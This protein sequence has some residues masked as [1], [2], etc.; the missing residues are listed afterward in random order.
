MRLTS[1]FFLREWVSSP[2]AREKGIVN[3][4]NA[5][6]LERICWITV[7][8]LERIRLYYKKPV[9]ITSGFR[10][11]ELNQAV[12]GTLNSAHRFPT[13]LFTGAVD[14]QVSGVSLPD[15]FNFVA[16]DSRLPYDQVILERGKNRDNEKDNCIHYAI[17]AEPRGEALLG[18]TLWQGDYRQVFEPIP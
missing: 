8:I 7:Y 12:G 9:I 11:P 5:V 13:E 15:V 4:P 18:M 16:F 17:A 6:Q 14:F 3:S 2:T 1:H 10:C